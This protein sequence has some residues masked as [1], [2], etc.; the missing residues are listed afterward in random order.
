[1]RVRA[2]PTYRVYRLYD[3]RTLSPEETQEGVKFLETERSSADSDMHG[4]QTGKWLV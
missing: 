4:L 1:L 3:T 2:I